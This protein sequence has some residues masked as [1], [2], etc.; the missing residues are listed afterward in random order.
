MIYNVKVYWE[1]CGV[2]EVEANSPQEAADKAMGPDVP[3]PNK[4]D[5]VEDSIN[6]DVDLDVHEVK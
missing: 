4:I 3:L 2:V 1:V 6:V 5:Y